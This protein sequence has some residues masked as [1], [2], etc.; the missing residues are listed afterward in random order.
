MAGPRGIGQVVKG[1]QEKG[2]CSAVDST[3]NFAVP[4]LQTLTKNKLCPVFPG[5]FD[6]SITKLS[7]RL[8]SKMIKIGIDGKKIARGKGAKMGYIDCWGFEKEPT[9]KDK[10]A[11]QNSEKHKVSALFSMCQ[12]LD[13]SF[14]SDLPKTFR[15]KVLTELN[16]ILKIITKRIED[17]RNVM[18]RLDAGLDKFLKLGESG[19]SNWR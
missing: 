9:L 5:I 3:I 7:E 4:S 2:E 17:L 14:V 19:G 13:I 6:D 8:P 16:D 10:E 1:S 11:R 12:K 18:I 15:T